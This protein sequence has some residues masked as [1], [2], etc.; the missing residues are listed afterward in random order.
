MVATR[1]EVRGTVE[2]HKSPM[3]IENNA[4]TSEFFGSIKKNSKTNALVAY[5]VQSNFLLL[6]LLPR[7]P[8]ESAPIILKRP[9]IPIAQ[10]ARDAVKPESVR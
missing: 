6:Y 4:T 9:I 1:P 2:S 8:A 3:L 10:A 5:S 7:T